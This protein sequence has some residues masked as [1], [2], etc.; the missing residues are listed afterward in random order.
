MPSAAHSVLTALLAAPL[1]AGS[2]LAAPLLV[3]SLSGCGDDGHPPTAPADMSIYFDAGDGGRIRRDASS[4][5]GGPFDPDAEVVD[6]GV[7]G[8]HLEGEPLKLATDAIDH[9]VRLVDVALSGTTFVV[10]W[11]DARTAVDDLYVYGWPAAEASG[12]EH[13]VTE[14]YSLTRDAQLGARADGF[15]V[16]WVDNL[17]GSYEL[18]ARPLDAMGAPSGPAQRLTNNVLREDSPRVTGL[19]GPTTMVAWLESDGSGGPSVTY[20]LP[21]DPTGAA[22]GTP[23]TATAAPRSPSELTLSRLGTGAALAWNESGSVYLQPLTSAGAMIGLATPI[24]TEANANGSAALALD[25]TGGGVAFGVRVGGARPEIRMRTVGPT[26]ATR[27]PEAILTPPPSTGAD[28]TIV[29]YA[30]GY[31]VAYRTS[32][33]DGTGMIRLVFATYNGEYSSSMDVAETTAIGG[34]PRIA[35]AAD[36]RMLI[37]WMSGD[38]TSA[39]VNAAKVVCE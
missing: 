16:S 15:M 30:T 20:A 29:A 10:A 26:G 36:G 7:R 25:E 13:R 39:A 35:I 19:G 28:P 34:A 22:V 17:T 27:G 24:N 9:S 38:L 2:L 18:Y 6:G 33:A 21:L 8:C 1:L 3:A 31:V 4:D 5:D 37:A 12:T 23:A 32:A 14:D 11:T